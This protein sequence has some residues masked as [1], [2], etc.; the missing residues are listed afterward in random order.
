MQNNQK[1]LNTSKPV[2][3]LEQ[4]NSCI[5]MEKATAF[6]GIGLITT[7]YYET[8]NYLI[9]KNTKSFTISKLDDTK[10]V[11]HPDLVKAVKHT[12]GTILVISLY[13]MMWPEEAAVYTSGI[14]GSDHTNESISK[15]T[16]DTDLPNNALV[17]NLL[18]IELFA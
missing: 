7:L 18:S 11:Y 5:F 15:L 2:P 16:N 12:V 4:K 9:N 17:S 10:T 6:V 13:N 1:T 8:A 14:I 3:I